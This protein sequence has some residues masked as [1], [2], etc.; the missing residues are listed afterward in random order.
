MENQIK[1]ILMHYKFN[2]MKFNCFQVKNLR[3]LL[4]RSIFD[5]GHV[6]SFTKRRPPLTAI[7]EFTNGHINRTIPPIFM[8]F[9]AKCLSLQTLS[10]EIKAKIFKVIPLI[11][12]HRSN[13]IPHI[14]SLKCIK[15]RCEMSHCFMLM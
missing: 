5:F 15:V 9:A 8:K 4:Q 11:S 7:L 6:T 10:S 12:P 1:A 14:K 2:G 13:Q 3:P